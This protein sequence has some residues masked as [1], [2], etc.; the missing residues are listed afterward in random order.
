[1]KK[2]STYTLDLVLALAS[3]SSALPPA[4]HQSHLLIPSAQTINQK[5]A[6]TPEMR[7]NFKQIVLSSLSLC[8]QNPGLREV[9]LEPWNPEQREEPIELKP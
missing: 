8:I 6:K 3:G 1:M 2:Y 4:R 5:K 9:D 7:F